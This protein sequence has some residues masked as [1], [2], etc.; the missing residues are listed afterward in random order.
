MVRDL[1]KCTACQACVVACQVE[2]SVSFAGPEQANMGRAMHWNEML[3]HVEGD[4]PNV[5]LHMVPRP[6]MQC[7]N[8]PCVTVCP[9]G[10]TWKN[11]EGLVETNGDTCIGCRYCMVACPYG[12]RSFN[13]QEPQFEEIQANYVNPDVPPRLRGVVE[14]CTYCSH[15]IRRAQAE[16]QPIGSDYEDGMVPACAQTCPASAIHFGDLDDPDSTVS[17]LAHSHRAFKLLDELGT[18]PKTIYLEEVS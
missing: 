12:A 1:D 16:G 9:V 18:E 11:E 2:N 3:V 13:W 5:H 7:E 17:R 15:R 10:A 14:K 6:C 8:P 4:F